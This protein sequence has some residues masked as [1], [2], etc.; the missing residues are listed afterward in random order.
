MFI[1]CVMILLLPLIATATVELTHPVN[2]CLTMLE[3]AIVKA[4]LTVC[5]LQSW[6]RPKRFKMSKYTEWDRAT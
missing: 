6:F 3:R 1:S 5:P 4:V 2:M